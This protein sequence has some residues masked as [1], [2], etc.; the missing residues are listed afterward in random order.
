MKTSHEA[1]M[2]KNIEQNIK[3]NRDN[4]PSE[5]FP[6]TFCIEINVFL[7]DK[8]PSSVLCRNVRIWS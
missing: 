3:D 8:Q 4:E 1:R 7:L 6:S 5:T 2:Q